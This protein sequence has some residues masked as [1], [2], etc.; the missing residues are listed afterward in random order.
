MDGKRLTQELRAQSHRLVQ[1]V[2][3]GLNGTRPLNQLSRWLT[4][5]VFLRLQVRRAL[6]QES[7]SHFGRDRRSPYEGFQV[8]S[9][10]LQLITPTVAEAAVVV[11]GR[12]R[13]R[14]V[15]IRWEARRAS[16][17]VTALEIG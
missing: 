5:D 10:R 4:P 6:V 15:A 2:M 7:Q 12:T 13:A 17:I 14:A 16:W 11:K 1:A 9:V 8:Q 3:E